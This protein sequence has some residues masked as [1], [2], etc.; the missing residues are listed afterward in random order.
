MSPTT[1]SSLFPGICIAD[2]DNISVRKCLVDSVVLSVPLDV[3]AKMLLHLW[4]YNFYDKTLF[5]E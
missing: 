5:T 3:C 4:S 2:T 1:P